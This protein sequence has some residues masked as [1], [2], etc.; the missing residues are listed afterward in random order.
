MIRKKG[1]LVYFWKVDRLAQ[2]LIE[3]KVT[4]KEEFKYY[5]FFSILILLVSD[6]LLCSTTNYT[7][8]DSIMLLGNI[9]ITIIGTY[10]TF[11]INSEGDNKEFIT[12]SVVLGLPVLVRTIILCTLPLSLV[13]V[14]ID[15]TLANMMLIGDN[16]GPIDLVL[17]FFSLIFYYWLLAKYIKIV[18]HK[19]T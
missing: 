3:G 13:A 18:S 8:Y 19:L 14:A 15:L 2:D 16:T 4:Q 7:I 10:I 11:K 1:F 12:R 17:T 9:L 5:L 6:P